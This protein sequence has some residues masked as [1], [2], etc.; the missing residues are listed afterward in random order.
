MKIVRLVLM[1]VGVC[2]GCISAAQTFSHVTDP[3]YEVPNLA[4]EEGSSKRLTE[5]HSNYHAFREFLLTLAVLGLVA[6]ATLD[7]RLIQSTVQWSA[8]AFLVAAYLLG[9]WL[10]WPLFDLRAPGADAVTAHLV[11]T[12]GLTGAVVLL[13]PAIA[14]DRYQS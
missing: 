2:V 5:T 6:W 1:I 13:A 3:T 8:L 4:A 14:S 7:R 11:A 12:I 9:W 10:P